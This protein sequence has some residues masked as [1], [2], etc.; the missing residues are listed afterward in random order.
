M[1]CEARLGELIRGTRRTGLLRLQRS[2]LWD[3]IR[4]DHVQPIG[5]TLMSHPSSMG[6]G[7]LSEELT[8][9]TGIGEAESSFQDVRIAGSQIAYVG[10]NESR[11][12]S[13]H[14][15]W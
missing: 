3:G 8:N 6:Q 10:N 5:P 15:Q 11:W 7:D 13:L 1:S 4:S 9:G 12:A 2:Q 14:H